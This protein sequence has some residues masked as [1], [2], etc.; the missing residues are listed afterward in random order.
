[1]I[2]LGL[3]LM[4]MLTNLI[5]L[6]S[7]VWL[8]H[9]IQDEAKLVWVR[10]YAL[11]LTVGLTYLSLIFF[12]TD[13]L[14]NIA[15]E[16]H[17][18]GYGWTFLNFQII[19]I[20]YA[21]LTTHS[22]AMLTALLAIVGCWFVW[23]TQ[24]GEL[25]LIGLTFCMIGV[26]HHYAAALN[27]H[28][29]LYYAVGLLFAAPIFLVNSQK[30]AGIDVG[31]PF[32]IVG[33]MALELALWLVNSHLAAKVQHE[34][35]LKREATIDSLTQLANFGCFDRDLHAAFD[36]YQTNG[37]LYALYTFD[38]DH[39]KRIN[40]RFGHLAGNEVLRVVSTHLTHWTKSLEYPAKVYR[41]GG[42]EFSILLFNIV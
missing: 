25:W 6:I 27:V 30:L 11:I 7:F 29:A 18:A 38:I 35:R 1:M 39:F 19:T 23:M 5:V 13:S 21:L 40:D 2:T 12:H 20:Y 32:Q 3:R 4:T 33:F 42:E 36:R 34:Q 9:W 15:N 16:G 17:P 28:Q 10:R 41:T 22:R 37:E 8:Y 31:W 24:G 26:I 14:L